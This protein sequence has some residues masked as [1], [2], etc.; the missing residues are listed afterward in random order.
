MKQDQSE[1]FEGTVD[2]YLPSG[3]AKLVVRDY[4]LVELEALDQHLSIHDSLYFRL[5]GR[6]PIQ[7]N[8]EVYSERCLAVLSEAVNTRV[9]T[10]GRQRFWVISLSRGTMTRLLRLDA[11]KEQGRFMSWDHIP[12]VNNLSRELSAATSAEQLVEISNQAISLAMDRALDVTIV[13]PAIYHLA[14]AKGDLSVAD[15]AAKTATN[16]R[17][18]ERAFQA[19]LGVSPNLE[20]RKVRFMTTVAQFFDNPSVKWKDLEF[21]PYVD[22]SH[23]LKEARFFNFKLR[24]LKAADEMAALYTRWFPEGVFDKDHSLSDPNQLP[25]IVA[26]FEFRFNTLRDLAETC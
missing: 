20:I 17:T 21:A 14:V 11:R 8:N 7:I 23:F 22:Q 5:S 18:L 3:R 13:E 16:R 15:L 9:S 1:T 4:A 25:A 12:W 10:L 26:N 19:R 24:Q 6:Y 2:H